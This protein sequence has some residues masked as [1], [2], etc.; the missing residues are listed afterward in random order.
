V[1]VGLSATITA[2]SFFIDHFINTKR[3]S[4]IRAFTMVTFIWPRKKKST[5]VSQQPYTTFWDSEDD[6]AQ[7][8][9]DS[10]DETE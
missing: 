6:L 9:A 8:F 7:V 3:Q 5:S 2:R 10:E 1:N 4:N